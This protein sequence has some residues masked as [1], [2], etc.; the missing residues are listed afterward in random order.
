MI[1]VPLAHGSGPGGP[2]FKS[3]RPDHFLSR[4]Q[5]AKVSRFDSAS[6]GFLALCPFCAHPRPFARGPSRPEEVPR[7]YVGE[8]D[9]IIE[10]RGDDNTPGDSPGHREERS[11]PFLS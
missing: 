1:D 10:V 8:E 11:T 7:E 3:L 5:T 2:E 4:F 6:K 9:Q